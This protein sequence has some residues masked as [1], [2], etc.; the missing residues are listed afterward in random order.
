MTQGQFYNVY[1]T[2]T[3]VSN[4][5][6]LNSSSIPIAA[7]LALTTFNGNTQ[8]VSTSFEIICIECQ[9]E[10]INSDPNLLPNMKIDILYYDSSEIN[11]STAAISGLEFSLTSTNIATLGKKLIY[12][13]KIILN[14]LID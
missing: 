9:K 7:F 11:T 6:P 12:Y 14:I 4:T 2:Q 8:F 5:F 1:P 10:L 13:F 3:I